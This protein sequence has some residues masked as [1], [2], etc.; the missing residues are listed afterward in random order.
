MR[1]ATPFSLLSLFLPFLGSPVHAQ[2]TSNIT[3][4][5]QDFVSTLQGA[6]FT[7]LA[8][9]LTTIND[10]TPGQTLFSE[11]AGG[12]NFT[13]FAPNNAAGAYFKLTGFGDLH[14]YYISAKHIVQ[15]RRQYFPPRRIYLLS[16][17]QWKL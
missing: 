12:R 15:H 1:F 3:S 6:G 9:V 11:L 10:T 14:N 4:Y 17:R 8:G 5:V 16:L 13:L 7:G 2:V